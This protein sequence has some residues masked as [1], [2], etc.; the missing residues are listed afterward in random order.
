M[1][2]ESFAQVYD[3]FMED[4]PYDS[5]TEY[6]KEIFKKHNLIHSTNIIADLGCG[7]GNMTERLAEN[8]FDMI[9]VDLSEEMLAIASEKAVEKNLDILYLNQDMRE[10]ELYG[11]VDA[12]VS[13]CDSINYITEPDDLLEVF[14]LVNNYLDPKG[15]FVFDIDT[16]YK[17]EKVLGCNSFC[18][19]TENSAYTWE[20]YYDN[21]EQINEFYTNF[22]I[23]TDNGL[24]ERH[25]EYHYERGY[26][27]ED[28]KE[29]LEEAG[30]VFEAVYDELTFHEPTERSQRIFFVAREK[31]KERNK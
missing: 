4:T 26:S 27:I 7:T 15:L 20:N 21:D 30:L 31:G 2:Y 12:I 28:I 22:F 24:Y 9:G 25:E 3:R 29:L 16:M 1:A 17:F 18:E 10:F 14:K 11:T 6:L 5:W 13:I 23:E 19:T 8:G